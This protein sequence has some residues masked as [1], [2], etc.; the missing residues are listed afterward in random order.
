MGA[1]V[2]GLSEDDFLMMHTFL[3]DDP[4]QNEEAE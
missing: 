2:Q 3:K 4:A 1:D